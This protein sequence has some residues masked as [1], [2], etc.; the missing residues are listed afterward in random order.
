MNV[1]KHFVILIGVGALVAPS[2]A[3][4]LP[5]FSN[6]MKYEEYGNTAISDFQ[7]AYGDNL[8]GLSEKRLTE[9]SEVAERNLAMISCLNR[10]RKENHSFAP[11]LTACKQE[12]LF[13]LSR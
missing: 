2:F 3:I 10:Y 12:L 4:A 5:W 8:S 13:D 1:P 11:A 6:N 9:A 7:K